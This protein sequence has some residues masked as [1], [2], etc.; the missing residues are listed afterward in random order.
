LAYLPGPVAFPETWLLSIGY[1][2][3]GGLLRA[4]EAPS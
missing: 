2:R 1:R 4:D 3:V